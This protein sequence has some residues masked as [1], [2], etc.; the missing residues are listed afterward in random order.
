MDVARERMWARLRREDGYTLTELLVALMIGLVVAAGGMTLLQIVVRAQPESAERSSQI[1][2]GRAM[3][4]ML[5]RELRQGESVEVATATELTLTTY[6]RS[7]D[8]DWPAG[9]PTPCAVTY[10][11]EGGSCSRIPAGGTAE[12]IVTGLRTDEVFSYCEVGQLGG[13]EAQPT[14]VNPGY[15]EVELSYPQV[16]G[17]EAVTFR[18]GVH[19]RNLIE[20]DPEAPQ[21]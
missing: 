12:I 21:A 4:E 11:C 14:A 5:T 9:E 2:Q 6:A 18:D 19:L 15:V 20:N 3:L 17:A 7:A 10:T 13:C 16:D 8:C 1:Q